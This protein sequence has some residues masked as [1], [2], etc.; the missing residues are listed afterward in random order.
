MKVP[1]S[2]QAKVTQQKILHYL[3]SENHPLGKFKSKFFRRL[4]FNENNISFFQTVL[5]ELLV[6]NDVLDAIVSPF[7]IKYIVDGKLKTPKNKTVYLR[8]IWIIEKE[9]SAPVLV[10]AYPK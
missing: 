9:Q 2:N 8:T 4:G 5:L 3:I 6:N 1:N 10:T 7:G